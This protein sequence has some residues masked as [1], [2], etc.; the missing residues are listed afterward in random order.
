MKIIFLTLAL[1]LSCLSFSSQPWDEASLL[2]KQTYFVLLAHP[3]DET[4]MNG[5]LALLAQRQKDIHVL[6]ATSGGEGNDYSGQGLAGEVLA[7]T[8]EQES[9]NALKQLGIKHPPIFLRHQDKELSLDRMKLLNNIKTAISDYKPEVVFT[10]EPKGITGHKDHKLMHILSRKALNDSDKSIQL[11][12][13][14]VSNKRAAI[15]EQLAQ[16]LHNPYRIKNSYP[17]DYFLL[18]THV[19]KTTLHR[20][21]AFEAYPTQF[22][23]PLQTLWKAFVKK[24]PYEEFIIPKK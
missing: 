6:Y 21:K 18:S 9:I 15:L 12:E 17:D 24:A 3:D 13:F 19:K 4:W 8:R 11:I 14:A 10:F 23:E 22:P 16:N 20:I 1:L 5:T 7:K 2:S